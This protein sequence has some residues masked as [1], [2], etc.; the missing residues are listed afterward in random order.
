MVDWDESNPNI[1][2]LHFDLPDCNRLYTWPRRM[3]KGRETIMK[4][5]P[6]FRHRRVLGL[7][8]IAIAVALASCAT[9]PRSAAYDP[10]GFFSGMLHGFLIFFSFV[11][12]L[13]TDVRIYNFPNSGGWYDFGY[14]L[15]ASIFLGGSG[16]AA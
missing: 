15:G 2:I 4:A 3:L 8:V 11:C 9:Q 6:R 5:R 1:A 13:F 12:S 14:L 10:P 16:S 7:I